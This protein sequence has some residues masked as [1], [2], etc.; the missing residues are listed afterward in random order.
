MH[1]FSNKSAPAILALSLLSFYKNAFLKTENM[2]LYLLSL[3][4]SSYIE[5]TI[6]PLPLQ[7]F[8]TSKKGNAKK[9]MVL[10]RSI[11]L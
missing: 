3:S 6:D 1:T 5:S 9:L 11:V 8:F 7:H 4:L 10:A 2:P